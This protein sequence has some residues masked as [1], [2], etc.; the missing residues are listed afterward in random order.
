MFQKFLIFLLLLSSQVLA[1]SKIEK[2]AVLQIK[3]EAKL[4]EDEI[5]FNPNVS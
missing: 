3:N 5:V 4:K 1:Q 2:I